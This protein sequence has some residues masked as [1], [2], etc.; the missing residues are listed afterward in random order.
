MDDFGKRISC[1]P[2]HLLTI[3]FVIISH[4]SIHTVCSS[5]SILRGLYLNGSRDLSMFNNGKEGNEYLY[6][7][8]L[9]YHNIFMFLIGSIRYSLFYRPC[10]MRN[11]PF[12]IFHSVVVSLCHHLIHV[13]RY[14]LKY[15]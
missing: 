15:W 6:V 7:F 13:H 9:T 2:T 10:V 12:C 5:K 3:L 4:L 14:I 11:I 1:L 8:C